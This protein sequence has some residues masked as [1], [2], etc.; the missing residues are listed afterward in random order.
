MEL[1]ETDLRR[2][3]S[4]NRTAEL[5]KSWSHLT[6]RPRGGLDSF[7]KPMITTRTARWLCRACK[8]AHGPQRRCVKAVKRRSSAWPPSLTVCY[9]SQV[10]ADSSSAV[11]GRTLEKIHG[12]RIAKWTYEQ[13]VCALQE[14]SRPLE[15]TFGLAK[16]TPTQ[17]L[18][19]QP[20]N[21]GRGHDQL[22]ALHE[23]V[24]ESEYVATASTAGQ[25]QQQQQA[26]PLQQEQ[27]SPPQLQQ[28]LQPTLQTEGAD[29]G[30]LRARLDAAQPTAAQVDDQQQQQHHH[31]HQHEHQP[32]A[33][34]MESAQ[35]NEEKPLAGPRARPVRHLARCTGRGRGRSRERGAGRG[36]GSSHGPKTHSRDQTVGGQVKPA[37][38]LPRMEALGVSQVQQQPL[39]SRLSDRMIQQLP[40]PPPS[41]LGM[42]PPSQGD[43]G[44]LVQK[45][46][47][48]SSIQL[49]FAQGDALT[50]LPLPQLAVQASEPTV[51]TRTTEA[52]GNDSSD[53]TKTARDVLSYLTDSATHLHSHTNVSVPIRHSVQRLDPG[54]QMKVKLPSGSQPG[55]LVRI[56]ISPVANKAS[57]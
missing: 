23:N 49:P 16:S 26:L 57:K 17:V 44:K 12:L 55:Q 35:P 46:P 25:Q 30:S 40:L 36:R 2:F 27:L 50:L 48:P 5:T 8:K 33:V 34:Q 56:K 14:V 45:R 24:L 29:G 19:E 18:T 1:T 38:M 15:L 51:T 9:A 11:V 39:E 28:Q 54:T 7:C 53:R 10:N 21:A 6:T 31:R 32:K 42:P 37:Q 3:V 43:E 22:L 13:V 41:H 20:L 47:P 52:V 4:S